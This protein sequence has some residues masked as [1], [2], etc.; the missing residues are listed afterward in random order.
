MLH[1]RRTCLIGDPSE[2]STCFIEDRHAWSDSHTRPACLRS[3][4]EIL[5]HISLNIYL[6]WCTFCLFIYFGIMKGLIQEPSMSI[7]GGFFIRHVGFIW[8]SDEE[9]QG[10]CWVSDQACRSPI[11]HVGFWWD[12]DEACWSPMGLQGGMS[13]SNKSCRG[14]WWVSDQSCRSPLKHVEVFYQACRSPMGFQ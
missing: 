12:S 1:R 8:V 6:F 9:C 5:T 7:Y 10:L 3:P 4:I 14:L 2:T 11:S 13:V